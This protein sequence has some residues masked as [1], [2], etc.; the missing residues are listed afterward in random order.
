MHP[1]SATLL[2]SSGLLLLAGCESDELGQRA[3][4]APPPS[5]Y[6]TGPA[7]IQPGL[8]NAQATGPNATVPVQPAPAGAAFRPARTREVEHTVAAGESLWSLSRKYETTIGEIREANQLT[9]DMIR[10]GQKLKIPTSMPEGEPFAPPPAP[11]ANQSSPPP[12][13]PN[14][15][16][17]RRTPDWT[18]T[19][20]VTPPTNTNSDAPQ[21]RIPEPVILPPPGG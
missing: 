3:T 4:T 11:G 5:P 16:S 1:N 13:I 6:E 7:P 2:L 17:V 20:P 10:A 9:S 12:E 14:Q 19:P 8:T 21:Y 18:V 15:A